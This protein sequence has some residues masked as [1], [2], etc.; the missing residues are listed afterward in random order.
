MIERMISVDDAF[1]S[2]SEVVVNARK[3]FSFIQ[4]SQAILIFFFATDVEAS[5]PSSHALLMHVLAGLFHRSRTAILT[6]K[7]QSCGDV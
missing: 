2:V 6:S 7:P 4:A 3:R 5:K 1:G